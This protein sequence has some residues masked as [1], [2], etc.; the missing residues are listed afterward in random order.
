[1]SKVPTQDSDEEPSTAGSPLRTKKY[2]HMFNKKLRL[3]KANEIVTD[4]VLNRRKGTE[5]PQTLQNMIKYKLGHKM[6][7]EYEK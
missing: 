3:N 1:M 7:D 2:A 4:L 5:D 6:G